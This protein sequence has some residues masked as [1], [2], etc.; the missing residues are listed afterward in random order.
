MTIFI[1]SVLNT[2][3][4][5]DIVDVDINTNIDIEVNIDIDL[6]DLLDLLE[7]DHISKNKNKI[8]L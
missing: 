6:S 2:L 7:I 4:T 8:K 1:F 5:F 3:S